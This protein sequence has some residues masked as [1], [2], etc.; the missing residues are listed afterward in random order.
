MPTLKTKRPTPN[1]SVKTP[2]NPLRRASSLRL[3][4]LHTPALEASSWYYETEVA[5]PEPQKTDT[6]ITAQFSVDSRPVWT[7]RL[8]AILAFLFPFVSFPWTFSPHE[9]PKQI[10]LSLGV[11]LG[12]VIILIKS[13]GKTMFNFFPQHVSILLGFGALI[14][15]SISAIRSGLLYQGLLG[16]G[17][18][19]SL[20][21]LALFLLG[22]WV[23]IS[24][25]LR[26]HARLLL[27]AFIASGSIVSGIT[28]AALLH[29]PLYPFAGTGFNPAG[30]T[31]LSGIIASITLVLITGRLL[32][33]PLMKEKILL[34][35]ALLCPLVLL[36]GIGFRVPFIVSAVGLGI[37]TLGTRKFNIN[38][39]CPFLIKTLPVL[40]GTILALI[41]AV[42]P[43]SDFLTTPLEISPSHRET[44]SITRQVWQESP[45]LGSGPT[46]FSADYLRF[47]SLPILKTPFWNI[48]FDWGSSAWLTFAATLGIVGS[49][50]LALGILS[51]LAIHAYK[52]L[53]TSASPEN[54]A[55]LAAGVAM[56]AATALAPATFSL[57]FLFATILGLM[58][59]TSV[60]PFLSQKHS[61]S[62]YLATVPLLSIVIGLLAFQTVRASAEIIAVRGVTASGTDIPASLKMVTLANKLNPFVDAYH[63]LA[64]DINRALLRNTLNDPAIALDQKKGLQ[65]VRETV[66]RTLQE[67]RN[68]T[69][70]APKNAGNW[71]TLGNVYLDIAPFTSGAASAAIDAFTKANELSPS[72]PS[73][74]VNLGIAKTIAARSGDDKEVAITLTNSAETFL[75]KAR[76]IRPNFPFAHLELA[77]LYAQTNKPE[78][79]LTAYRNAEQIAQND[80]ALRYEIG[81]FL[82]Q[83]KQNEEAKK[84][85]SEA[86]RLAPNFS[87]ARWYLAQVYEE[88]GRITEAIEQMEKAV[89]LNP[90]N[91]TAK[92][93][94]AELMKKE[95]KEQ[96]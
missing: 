74:L 17:G 22:M 49:G 96:N 25:N 13:R 77:R 2:K 12:A 37:L 5:K 88:T 30:T 64:S 34:W 52:T 44:W 32:A 48:A 59:G 41:L 40:A 55:L 65:L 33:H 91:E 31:T 73:I 24:Y 66:D 46:S 67:A 68:A 23:L 21:V 9:F 76:E 1:K 27:H 3:P 54:S 50:F 86:V 42:F 69:K 94:L 58:L 15:A 70:L 53:K 56:F 18:T 89:E 90:Q 61:A 93:R 19:E 4:A 7:G 79:A 45:L 92:T 81:L 72:D 35:I 29:V 14:T 8:M 75:R 95:T 57:L 87:N 11:A 83:T 39:G 71:V 43:V 16:Q 28:I 60:A 20:S 10:F 38:A 63:R 6:G 47:R 78:E 80:P 84:E 51:I 36:F 62:T 85:L 26:V 82:I